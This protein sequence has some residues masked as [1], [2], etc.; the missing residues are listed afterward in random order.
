[1]QAAIFIIANNQRPSGF[2]T[3]FW[4]SFRCNII[5]VFRNVLL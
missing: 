3:K 4:Q 2:V 5:Y 1:M